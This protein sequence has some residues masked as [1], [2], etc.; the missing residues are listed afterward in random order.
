[1]TKPSVPFVASDSPG[2]L[3]YFFLKDT[4]LKVSFPA[5]TPSFKVPKFP[6]QAIPASPPLPSRSLLDLL[7]CNHKVISWVGSCP[8]KIPQS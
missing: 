4:S 8:V 6:Q 1:M 2:T 5:S 7:K 3:G